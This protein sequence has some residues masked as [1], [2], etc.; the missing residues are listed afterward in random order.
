MIA[1]PQ[2]EHLIGG[3]AVH[4]SIRAV[5]F[6]SVP[7]LTKNTLASGILESAGD[8]LGQFDLGRMRYTVEECSI[9]PACSRMASTTSGM[10]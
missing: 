8:P 4:E 9:R 6:A 2:G 3:P 1:V 7:E 10:L 5:S